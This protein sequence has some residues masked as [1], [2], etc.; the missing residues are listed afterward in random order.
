MTGKVRV[1][2]C[3]QFFCSCVVKFDE[4]Q[5]YYSVSKDSSRSFA[6]QPVVNNQNTEIPTVNSQDGTDDPGIVPTSANVDETTDTESTQSL[7]LPSLTDNGNLVNQKRAIKKP[8]R[9]GNPIQF[10]DKQEITDFKFFS[11]C[12]SEEKD[13]RKQTFSDAMISMNCESWKQAI[14][15]ELDSLKKLGVYDMVD[16]PKDF[17]LIKGK[18]IFVTKPVMSRKAI[19]KFMVKIT[20][21]LFHPLCH[22]QQYVALAAKNSMKIHQIDVK[23]AFLISPIKDN[24][25]LEQPSGS[26]QEGYEDKVWKLKKK[27]VW[28]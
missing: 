16:K 1:I 12:H 15:S 3:I 18:W 13:L 19:D 2:F 7:L 9:L 28:P 20:M 10:P 11:Q 24:I 6:F 17:P 25:Y 23:T 22:I 26:I 27:F 5:F 21:E 8:E 4:Q 14:N